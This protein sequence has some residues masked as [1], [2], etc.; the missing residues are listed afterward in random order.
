M[1]QKGKGLPKVISFADTSGFGMY[2]DA[3]CIHLGQIES[4]TNPQ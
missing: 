1:T 3:I 2:N 4:I